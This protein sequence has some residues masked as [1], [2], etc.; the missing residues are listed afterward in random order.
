MFLA[1]AACWGVLHA[2]KFPVCCHLA[3]R[4][5][6]LPR[7]S[8]IQVALCTPSLQNGPVN[9][10]QCMARTSCIRGDAEQRGGQGNSVRASAVQTVVSMMC[11]PNLARWSSWCTS[12]CS[13]PP[14]CDKLQLQAF[15]SNCAPFLLGKNM[16]HRLSPIFIKRQ[17]CRQPFPNIGFKKSSCQDRLLHAER[18][19]GLFQALAPPRH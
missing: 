18:T 15:R 2:C 9:Q 1:A 6:L 11:M 7:C 17:I 19:V 16:S 3:S 10:C 12:I 8:C 13:P 4:T 14:L 5:T